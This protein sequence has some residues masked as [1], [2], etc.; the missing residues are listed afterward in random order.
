MNS[1]LMIDVRERDEFDAEHVA[2]TTHVPLSQFTHRA[3]G[4]L[5]E[6]EGE[7]V[8]ILCR[9]GNRARLAQSQIQQLGFGDR[10]KVSV[11]EGG[12][13]AWKKA[14][15]PVVTRKKAHLPI[16]RQVQLVAGSVVLTSSLLAVFVNPAFAGIAAFFGA[17]LTFAGATGFC[18]MANLLAWMPWNRTLPQTQEE[19]C[20]VSPRSGNC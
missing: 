4:V 13:L 6:F 3:P 12:I 18:G 17:G 1:T 7:E 20:S 8:Q 2:G 10:F 11:V 9:S 16:L 14:G 19:L 15:K 5:N